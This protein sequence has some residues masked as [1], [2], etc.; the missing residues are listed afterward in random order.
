M[1]IVHEKVEKVESLVPHYSIANI[2]DLYLVGGSY[3][4]MFLGPDNL[5]IS[6]ESGYHTVTRRDMYRPDLISYEYYGTA[7]FWWVI[8]VANNILD[9]FDMEIGLVLR[10]PL[11]SDVLNKWLD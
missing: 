2:M 9:P 5:Y 11:K 10:I 6:S 1:T 4:S 7:N 8:L 3:V